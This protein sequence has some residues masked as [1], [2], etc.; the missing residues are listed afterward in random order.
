MVAQIYINGAAVDM[1]G[2]ALSLSYNSNLLGKA[3][4]L[5]A[6]F[7]YTIT[8]PRSLNNDRLLGQAW[9]ATVTGAE[10]NKWLPC[11]Y[12]LGGVPV[13]SGRLVVT[14]CNAS[15]Y[16]CNVVWGF[17]GLDTMRDEG[18]KL[19]GLAGTEWVTLDYDTPAAQRV[20]FTW[21]FAD[22]DSGINGS[23]AASDGHPRQLPCVSARYILGK[24]ADRYGV[25]LEL[26]ADAA[27][28]VDSLVF[29]LTSKYHYRGENYPQCALTVEKER[30]QDDPPH[31]EMWWE[32]G[33]TGTGQGI[34]NYL[35]VGGRTIWTTLTDSTIKNYTMTATCSYPFTAASAKFGNHNAS[36]VGVDTYKVTVSVDSAEAAYGESL[37]FDFVSNSGSVTDEQLI[38]SLV[39]SCSFT[40][41]PDRNEV[42]AKQGYPI[43][44][45]FPDIK[46]VEFIAEL[47]AV[48][49]VVPVRMNG[50]ALVCVSWDDLMNNPVKID[51]LGVEKLSY[52]AGL[53]QRNVLE[54]ATDDQQPDSLA[55]SL[56]VNDATLESESKWHTSHFCA[57][58]GR[59]GVPLYTRERGSD[60]VTVTTVNNI[61]ERVGVLDPL[62]DTAYLVR[63][64]L[65][66]SDILAA[67]YATIQ[68]AIT[69]PRVITGQA[70]ITPAQ[71]AAIDYGRA[72]YVEQL[73]AYF[74]VLS[75]N[76]DAGDIYNVE[77]L[78]L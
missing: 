34:I 19:W 39:A 11:S 69:K 12:T 36:L 22:Y 48:A 4:S 57:M 13:F 68:A 70:H 60:G 16:G 64:G 26:P 7:S 66:W 51:L 18:L 67:R 72:V 37:A 8:L 20:G 23:V 53:A 41:I 73:A 14:E 43:V 32:A 15:G 25:T 49:G 45:N 58:T 77:L 56:T 30:V 33:A 29:A 42:A 21:G 52:R 47:C 76:S 31:W 63:D 59:H 65:A 40:C 74:A 55:A 27:A 1:G 28:V 78:K 46:C 10:V 2:E 35:Q 62:F 44:T 17:E 61:A 38:P 9:Q 24:I 54:W 3:D 6:N 75:I 5:T 71:L 50:R